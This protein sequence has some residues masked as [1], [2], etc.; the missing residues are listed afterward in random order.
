MEKERRTIAIISPFPPGSGSHQMLDCFGEIA[1]MFEL[2]RKGDTVEIS[3]LCRNFQP[4][5]PEARRQHRRG[6][7]SPSRSLFLKTRRRPLP[8][9][10]LAKSLEEQ[11]NTNSNLRTLRAILTCPGQKL[12]NRCKSECVARTGSHHGTFSSCLDIL[13]VQTEKE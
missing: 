10:S 3:E 12:F 11:S 1:K 7:F 13:F 4:S 2:F 6:P 5:R 8:Y 9:F